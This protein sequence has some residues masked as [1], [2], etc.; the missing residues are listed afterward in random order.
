MMAKIKAAPYPSEVVPGGVENI[1][2]LPVNS[3]HI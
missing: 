2:Q 1:L 3:K